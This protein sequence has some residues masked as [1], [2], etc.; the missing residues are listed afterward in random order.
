[1][2]VSINLNVDTGSCD[3]LEND[4]FVIC[5]DGLTNMVSNDEIKQICYDD[6]IENKA[7]TLVNSAINYGGKDNITCIVV[8]IK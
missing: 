8:E 4:K 2:G 6:S 5:S 7:Q 1:M 3:I